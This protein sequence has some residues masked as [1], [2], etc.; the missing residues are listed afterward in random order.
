MDG[1]NGFKTD[2]NMKQCKITID[3]PHTYIH[4]YIFVWFYGILIGKSSHTVPA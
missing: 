2:N 3:T 4:L 1:M